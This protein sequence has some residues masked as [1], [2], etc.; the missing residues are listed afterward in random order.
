MSQQIISVKLGYQG[1]AVKPLH[2]ALQYLIQANKIPSDITNIDGLQQEIDKSFFGDQTHAYTI[3]AYNY[4]NIVFTNDEVTDAFYTALESNKLTDIVSTNFKL[5]GVLTNQHG[6]PIPNASLEVKKHFLKNTTFIADTITDVDGKYQID[7]A[8]NT[9]FDIGNL[10]STVD[11]RF[12]VT[13]PDDTNEYY[14]NIFYNI[15]ES[16]TLDIK[17]EVDLAPDIK[18]EYEDINEKLQAAFPNNFNDLDEDDAEFI[19]AKIGESSYTILKYLLAKKYSAKTGLDINLFYAVLSYT[20]PIPLEIITNMS[21]EDIT[22]YINQAIATNIISHS[23]IGSAPAF[24]TALS[25]SA[26]NIIMNSSGT[27]EEQKTKEILSNVFTTQESTAFVDY[28]F[29]NSANPQV[30]DFGNMSAA[31]SFIDEPKFK[32]LDNVLKVSNFSGNNPP[33]LNHILTENKLD[34]VNLSDS[35]WLNKITVLK[36]SN[37]NTFILPD[38]IEGSTEA[39]RMENYAIMLKNNINSAYIVESTQKGIVD[40]SNF[41]LTELQANLNTFIG[42]NPD[43]NLLKTNIADL[44]DTQQFD[45]TNI[46]QTAFIEEVATLQR[47]TTITGDLTASKALIEQN[48]TSASSIALSDRIT[49]KD[50]LSGYPF[51]QSSLDQ[52]YDGAITT[53]FTGVAVAFSLWDTQVTVSSI[54]STPAEANPEWRTLFPNTLDICCC[55]HCNSVFSPAAYMVDCLEILR[56]QNPNVFNWL[57]LKRPDI[58]Q[59]ELT[60]KNTNTSLPYIDIVNEVLEDMMAASISGTTAMPNITAYNTSW[61]EKTLHAIPQYI[62]TAGT[63]NPYTTLKSSKYPWTGPY[64]YFYDQIKEHLGIVGLKP[65]Q[66][67][68]SISEREKPTL[69]DNIDDACAYLEITSELKTI[70]LDNTTNNLFDYYGFRV[71]GANHIIIDPQNRSQILTVVGTSLLPTSFNLMNRVDIFLQQSGECYNCLLEILECYYLNPNTSTTSRKLSIDYIP[72]TRPDGKPV[73]MDTCSLNELKIAGIDMN[74]LKRIHIFMRLVK[75][76]GWTK[77]TLDKVFRTL[78]ISQ[79]GLVDN[80]L[81][82]IAQIHYL[83]RTLRL[84]VDTMLIFWRDMEDYVYSSYKGDKP[85]F[86]LSEY[87]SYFRNNKIIPDFDTLTNYPFTARLSNISSSTFI[88]NRLTYFL[89]AVSM[90]E[91]DFDVLCKTFVQNSFSNKLQQT[92]TAVTFNAYNISFLLR[93]SILMNALNFSAEEWGFYRQAFEIGF[94]GSPYATSSTTGFSA[95][96]DII[97]HLKLLRSLKLDISDYKKFFYDEYE[98]SIEMEAR[99]EELTLQVNNLKNLLSKNSE[100]IIKGQKIDE[101]A[102]KKKYGQLFTQEIVDFVYK[103]IGKVEGAVAPN[104]IVPSDISTADKNQFLTLIPSIYTAQDIDAI[105]ARLFDS[106]TEFLSNVEARFVE[107]ERV[108]APIILKSIV[109]KYFESLFKLPS[110]MVEDYL[111]YKFF[112]DP[113]GSLPIHY[114]TFDIYINSNFKDLE[115]FTKD[116][117]INGSNPLSTRFFYQRIDSFSRFAA[118]VHKFKL[119][120]SEITNHLNIKDLIQTPSVKLYELPTGGAFHGDLFGKVEISD[121]IRFLVWMHIRKSLGNIKI[122][123]FE[124]INETSTKSTAIASKTYWSDSLV[125]SLGISPETL[126]EFVGIKTSNATTNR[127]VFS[128]DFSITGSFTGIYTYLRLIA[129]LDMLEEAEV[130]V[131]SLKSMRTAINAPNNQNNAN[132]VTQVI[133]SKY[134]TAEWLEVI[135]PI[136]DN[137]RIARRDAM[138][139]YLLLSP[140]K[141]YNHWSNAN[142]IYETLFIDTQ[143]MPIVKTSRIRLHISSIQVFYER[144]IL[145][146]ERDASGILNLTAE[147]NRQ[148]NLWRKYYRIWEAN[149]KVFVYPE[150]WIEPEL[151]DDKSPFFKELEKFLKQNELTEDNMRDAYET[152]LERLEEV[153]NLEIVCV[154]SET[155]RADQYFVDPGRDI[156]HV[157]GR[158]HSMPNI[159]YYRKREFNEWTPWEKMNVE[160]EGDNFCAIKHNGRLK[161]FWL[162]FEEKEIEKPS[163]IKVDEEETKEKYWDIGLRWTEYK[164]NKWLPIQVSKEWISAKSISVMSDKEISDII[165]LGQLGLFLKLNIRFGVNVNLFY[166]DIKS[167]RVELERIK[168]SILP[169]IF[170]KNGD[171]EICISG[172]Q[173]GISLKEMYE[174]HFD[175]RGNQIGNPSGRSGGTT[176]GSQSISMYYYLNLSKTYVKKLGKFVIHGKKVKAY[177]DHEYDTYYEQLL[178]RTDIRPVNGKFELV[179]NN[180][181]VLASSSGGMQIAT[182]KKSYADT[183]ILIPKNIPPSYNNGV[184][185][186]D[187]SVLY[188]QKPIWHKKFFFTDAQNTCFSEFHKGGSTSVY[189]YSF[190]NFKNYNVENFT[191]TLVKNGISGIFD[192]TFIQNL[193]STDRISFGSRYLP[194]NIYGGYPN[195]NLNFNSNNPNACYNWELLFHIPMLIANKLMKD[196]K[197]FEAMKWYHYVFNPYN[198]SG[199]FPKPSSKP[200]NYPNVERFWHFYPF[201]E[202]ASA[203]V[204]TIQTIMSDPNYNL[205]DAVKRWAE[206]PF[207]PHL[208]A[209]TRYGAYMK[210][211]VMKY[212]D[213]LIAWGDMLFR[214]DTLESINEATILYVLAAQLLGRRPDKC[215][216]QRVSTGN[217]KYQDFVNGG[218]INAFSNA[219]QRIES[220]LSPTL[221]TQVSNILWF[222]PVN[223]NVLTSSTAIS[224]N[225]GIGF[226]LSASFS[227]PLLNDP[228]IGLTPVARTLPTSPLISTLFTDSISLINDAQPFIPKKL[229]ESMPYNWKA[230]SSN[231]MM[232]YFCIPQNEKLLSYWDLVADRLFK[233]RNSQNIEGV[234]RQLALF[235]PPID[236]AILVKAV[237]SGLSLA[238][239]VSDLYAPMPNYRFQILSQKASELA[240]E[241]KS[242]GASLLS[243]LEK[244]DAESIALL[245]SSKE[246]ELLEMVSELRAI[247]IKEAQHQLASLQQ[248]EKMISLR[249]DYYSG[250]ISGGLNEGESSQLDSMKASIPLK[251]RAQVASSLAGFIRAFPDVKIGSPFSIGATLGGT[252]FGG[253]AQI[254]ADIFNIIA[255]INDIEGSMAGIKGGY[256]R[257]EQDWKQQLKST[258]VELKQI[259]KQLLAA[260]IR[261]EMSK[262]EYANHLKQIDNAK[263][264]DEAMHNKYTNEDLYDWMIG[265]ISA[266][267]FQSYKLAFDTARKAEKCYHFELATDPATAPK[268][269]DF[270]YWDSLRKGLLSGESLLQDIKRME[271][272][273]LDNNK[274]LYEMTKHISLAQ[275]NPAALLQ[276]KKNKTVSFKLPEWLFDMDHPG[277]YL[278]RIKSVSISI[279]CVAG[280]YTTVAAKLTLTDNSIRKTPLV[281]SSYPSSGAN[282]SRFSTYFMGGQSIATSSAQNDSGMFELNFKDERYLPFEG[283]GVISTWTLEIPSEFAQFDINSVSDIIMHINYTARYDGGLKTAANDYLKTEFESNADKL[284]RIINLKQEFANE[285][286]AYVQDVKNSVSNASLTINLNHGHFPHFCEGKELTLMTGIASYSMKEGLG[287]SA[288]VSFDLKSST[289]FPTT[290]PNNKITLSSPNFVSG[291]MN[292]K[293]NQKIEVGL[294]KEVK[295]TLESTALATD[296]DIIRDLFFVVVYKRDQ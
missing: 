25:L 172:T 158:T 275:I 62:K 3:Q 290:A 56:R 136:N 280:P 99:K 244:K 274:R 288:A 204:P 167:A 131:A 43:F 205:S 42:N 84:E 211:V 48:F 72:G 141:K 121:W 146:I 242:L 185:Y 143:M 16:Q 256:A 246:I 213:N 291:A 240:Q 29:N 5:S 128:L 202:H 94:L 38:Y 67:L 153:A 293:T 85:E 4:L 61:D 110:G 92:S 19:S 178:T 232:Y 49:F 17:V 69:L 77:Y 228:N 142:D 108:F 272:S 236:P 269:I 64:N 292:L 86:V 206:N 46:N 123:L 282:D 197:F 68:Q 195:S 63:T 210:N 124:I 174:S 28:Y 262:Y 221:M 41:P 83:S 60:C 53:Y 163:K 52:M 234:E 66:I 267:Y 79:N 137:M 39:E 74:D 139:S 192:K 193:V 268:F 220:I 104:A 181:N 102:F 199:Q 54:Y 91:I 70:L 208:V 35:E 184:L 216:P 47:V 134:S 222:S 106:G 273:Y 257:R 112:T 59:I 103:K 224:S 73:P 165:I 14:T 249:R 219:L 271:V 241:V 129:A 189:K 33:V 23:F 71:D 196:Q 40:D 36:N 98:T 145:Q 18:S 93:E 191:D 175:S 1:E 154:Y 45:Y 159:Y 109:V 107:I 76:L 247:Q 214:R 37:P 203:G 218:N 10:E 133:K 15:I 30:L 281:G 82:R 270:G 200:A 183:A 105:E 117:L 90:P 2:V 237:A 12:K 87:E 148:W 51:L 147:D 289:L 115:N 255:T 114:S 253:A 264:I 276:F 132:L 166:Y 8:R 254:A 238:D 229:G 22:K 173:K 217:K 140:P 113:N 125:T 201:Y 161:L 187:N 149:R 58:W 230:V 11:I 95:M 198:T 27:P 101:D 248:Q 186:H 97:H 179:S 227:S 261:V 78:G 20:K 50:T 150:N 9:V 111:S 100:S 155:E 277:Q 235:E 21:E 180:L 96:I 144:V 176:T 152:Y 284:V 295:F 57:K 24:Y 265:E 127:G 162:T 215:I 260:Q 285:W 263:S 55:D 118:L 283:A 126:T 164:S 65:Y 296:I 239:A 225:L 233:I 251:I 243:A 135:K 138:V 207:K 194:L 26:T 116:S 223:S 7:V 182:R 286:N 31:L 80:D 160:I 75:K 209:R 231:V 177:N 32:E 151:R 190:L 294:D 252:N 226:K 34:L 245:R 130:T 188:Q 266:T 258:N 156:V 119:T 6:K 259:E 44:E 250:L 81:I 88:D 169:Y 122:P 171:L 170:E 287:A 13:I 212:I 168:K 157:W 89:G 120:R 279:P 278:R